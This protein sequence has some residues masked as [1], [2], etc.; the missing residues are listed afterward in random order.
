MVQANLRSL[1]T[2]F[3]IQ[4]NTKANTFHVKKMQAVALAYVIES[5][6]LKAALN[7]GLSVSSHSQ[8]SGCGPRLFQ[9]SSEPRFP[10]QS[11]RSRSFPLSSERLRTS[12]ANFFGFVPANAHAARNNSG[13]TQNRQITHRGGIGNGP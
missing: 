10:K 4:I 11:K 3:L 5:R 1:T 13:M 8:P 7:A 2:G 9:F 12:V 6:S